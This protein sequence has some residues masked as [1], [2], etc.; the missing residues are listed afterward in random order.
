MTM[1]SIDQYTQQFIKGLVLV[2]AV[3]F[4]VFIKNQRAKAN[5]G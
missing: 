4:D 3:A 2:A 5:L 1:L